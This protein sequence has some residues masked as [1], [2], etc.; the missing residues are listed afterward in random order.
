MTDLLTHIDAG[1]GTAAGIRV[2]I[3][4]VRAVTPRGI[5]DDA[6]VTVQGGVIVEVRER[7]TPSPGAI[8]GRGAFLVPGLVDACSDGLDK[9]SSPCQNV[10]LPFDFAL[11]S[12]E[13]RVRA[14]GITTVLHAVAFEHDASRMHTIELA[15]EMS[16]AIGAHRRGGE[17]I[18]DHRMASRLDIDDG[19]ACK[20]L[21][22]RLE[23]SRLAAGADPAELADPAPLVCIAHRPSGSGHRAAAVPPG[24]A[25]LIQA[26]ASREVRLMT[27]APSDAVDIDDAQEWHTSLVAFPATVA[28]ATAAKEHGLTVVGAAPTVLRDA[29]LGR[30]VSTAELVARG[31]CDLLVSDFMPSTLLGAATALV[32]GGACDLARAIDLV[33]AGPAQALGLSDRGRLVVGLRA[34]LVLASISGRLPTVRNVWSAEEVPT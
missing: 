7:G 34:D 19:R 10:Q 32:A 11:R 33:T 22:K 2:C 13:G 17:A 29:R 12:F 27:C 23:A 21:A 4:N 28:A 18:V 3:R 8:D 31:L 14:A 15:N 24:L 5:V 26:A 20:A 6:T 9:E 1:V 30:T 16:D 25:W